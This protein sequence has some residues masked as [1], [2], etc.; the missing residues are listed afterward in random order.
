MLSFVVQSLSHVWLFVTP[1]IAAHQSSLSFTISWVC[2]N[3]CPLSQWCRPSISSSLIPFSCLQSFLASGS[4]PISQLFTSGGQSIV[5]SASTSVLPMNIQDWF[6][7]G[8]T[9]LITLQSKELSRIFSNTTVKEHQF[10]GTHASLWSNSHPHMTTGETI[11]LTT[12]TFV[13]KVMS[14][15]FNMLSGVCHNFPSKE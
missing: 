15:L 11:A 12:E 7:L 3:S 8:L 2:S 10:F 4:F 13:G 9:G 14:L 1:W 6:H 5:A